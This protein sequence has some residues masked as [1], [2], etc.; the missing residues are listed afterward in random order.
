MIEATEIAQTWRKSS[1]SQNGDCVEVMPEDGKLL[2]RD[3]KNPGDSAL[4]FTRPSGEF[5]VD[6]KGCCSPVGH[7]VR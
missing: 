1:F 4:A 3:S 2:V 6:T 7:S 5:N